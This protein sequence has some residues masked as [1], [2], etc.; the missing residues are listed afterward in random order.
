M[1]WLAVDKDGTETIFS[2][3]P[4]RDGDIW[5]PSY[6]YDQCVDIPKGT[7]KKILGHKLT[8]KDESVEI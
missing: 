2:G 3:E 5:R 7:I 6:Q 1:A 8:W 4:F